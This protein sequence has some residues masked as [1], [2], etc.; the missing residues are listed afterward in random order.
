M[1][2]STTLLSAAVLLSLSFASVCLAQGETKVDYTR[3]IARYQQL[4]ATK[5]PKDAIEKQITSERERI[6]AQIEDELSAFVKANTAVSSDTTDL[7]RVI[8]QQRTVVSSLS[9][10]VDSSNVDLDLL[11]KEEVFY[12]EGMPTGTGATQP[13]M[14]TS[15]YPE[16]LAKKAVLEERIDATKTMLTAQETRLNKLKSEQQWKSISVLINIL[17]YIFVF[18][19]VIW[20]EGIIRKAMLLHIHHRGIRYTATKVFTLVVYLSL[21]FWITQKIYSD[22]PGIIAVVAVV[23]AAFVFVLQDALRGLIG[24]FAQKGSLAL[25][26]RVT[27][28]SV[29]GDVLDIGMFHTTLLI[30]RSPEMTDFSQVGKIV[31][32]PNVLLSSAPFVNY[33]ATSDFENVEVPVR[34]AMTAQWEKAYAILEDILRA[35]TEEYSQEAQRQMD[36]RMRGFYFSQVS[37]SWRVYMELVNDGEMLFTLCFPAPIGK[38]RS[39]ATKVTQQV[40]KRFEEEGIALENAK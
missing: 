11:D 14:T 32:I 31:R 6:H 23:G 1:K 17:F 33:H 20:L 10:R 36:Q 12:K 4:L 40:L 26:Q 22:L 5:E 37:P 30:S 16:L 2:R 38:R 8:E 15:S 13:F 29:T 27:I 28:G 39:V 19:T 9:E 7:S 18:I 3:L 35:E 25:G 34:I 24:W 21:I